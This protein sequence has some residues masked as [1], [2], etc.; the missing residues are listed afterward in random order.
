MMFGKYR[1]QLKEYEAKL[2][3]EDKRRQTLLDTDLGTYIDEI[4]KRVGNKKVKVK[5][6]KPTGEEIYFEPVED[7]V[8]FGVIGGEEIY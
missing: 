2:I 1:K 7:K 4:M 6:R 5:I 8:N 3:A